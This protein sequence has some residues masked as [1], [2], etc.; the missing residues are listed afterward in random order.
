MITG[1]RP[2]IA[3]TPMAVAIK[4]ITDP[5]PRPRDLAPDLPDE[6]ERVLIKALAKQPEDRPALRVFTHDDKINLF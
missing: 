5:L 6:A 1:R 4:H 2:F 3:D